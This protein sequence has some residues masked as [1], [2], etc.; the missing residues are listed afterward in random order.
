MVKISDGELVARL[1]QLARAE[2]AMLGEVLRLLREVERRKLHVDRAHPS[3]FRFCVKELGYTEHEAYARIQV[4]RLLKVVPEVEQAVEDGRIGMTVASMAQQYF[5]RSEKRKLPLDPSRQKA[6]VESL[7]D[8]ATRE[9]EKKLAELFPD[10]PG[11]QRS[12]YRGNGTV[13]VSF[14]IHED[15][16]EDVQELFRIRSHTNPEKRWEKLLGD[17]V[18]L[19][20]KK[21]H[22]IARGNKSP[23]A[24]DEATSHEEN[25]QAPPH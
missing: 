20:W 24:L 12:S 10:P 3:L 16:Y 8:C 17:L 11:R 18:K 6:I 25:Q 2:R 9:A 7:Y 22:P 21:W 4:T 19:G 15:L 13:R 14:C 23:R 5:H 1:K